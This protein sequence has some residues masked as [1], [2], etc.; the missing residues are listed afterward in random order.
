MKIKKS[1]IIVI[2]LGSLKLPIPFS[3]FVV[4]FR[5]I[6]SIFAG[7]DFLNNEE[8]FSLT[9]FPSLD[10]PAFKIPEE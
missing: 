6:I 4:P 1:W 5:I 10:S 7:P 3:N 9:I 2:I 8:I